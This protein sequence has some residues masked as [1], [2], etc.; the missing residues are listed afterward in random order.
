MI[1]EAGERQLLT[2]SVTCCDLTCKSC[3]S[4]LGVP[5]SA[6]GAGILLLQYGTDRNS[7]ILNHSR[8]HLHCI[9]KIMPNTMS[10][11]FLEVIRILTKV[12]DG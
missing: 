5:F 10:F 2:S 12:E 7:L 11:R 4:V 8:A 3:S 1:T 9:M 6:C